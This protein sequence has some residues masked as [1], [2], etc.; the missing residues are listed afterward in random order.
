MPDT[1]R[2]IHL[3]A[4]AGSCRHM[5]ADLECDR[6]QQLIARI[7]DLVG[8]SY[9]VTGNAAQ[10][11]AAEDDGRGG[12]DDDPRRAAD[13]QK[14]M[15][16]DR[17]A[18][19]V[20]LRGGAWLTRIL[21]RIE[22]D[23]LRRRE[24]RVALFGFS[25]MTTVINIA[26]A[27]PQAVCWYDMGPAF[28]PAGLRLWARNQKTKG[29][30]SDA[31]GVANE[32]GERRLGAKQWALKR[33]PDELA[34]FFQD[35]IDRIEGRPS[36]GRI[37]GRLVSGRLPA[38]TSTK[39]I[40][41]TL[42][43]LISL[44]GTPYA[45]SIFRRGRWLALEDVGEAPHRIDRMLAH[46]QLAGILDRCDGLLLGDFHDGVDDQIEQVLTS[47][48]RVLPRRGRMPIVVSR[49]FGHTWPMAPLPIGQT[50]RLIR[51]PPRS[52]REVQLDVPWPKLATRRPA[53]ENC[54]C[55]PT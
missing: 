46:L 13:L 54:G 42:S 53:Q 36:R 20:A 41:G 35:V 11:E 24:T 8:P 40:G 27:Y 43:V 30:S 28:I 44:I 25:E 4:P 33:Y 50:V 48:D 10:I 55:R 23:V 18:G 38:R 17:V 31:A 14:A 1:T 51:T 45:R 2:R 3:I 32:P 9:R 47:L 52:G 26:A 49:D 37:T 6:A 12:R 15:A 22:F 34:A 16:D 39:I 21:P 29:T 5:L 19:I 7:Q